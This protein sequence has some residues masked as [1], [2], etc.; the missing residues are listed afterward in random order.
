MHRMEKLGSIASVWNE[1]ASG[2]QRESCTSSG[3]VR[4][5]DPFDRYNVID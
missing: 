4:L 3:I 5:I 1:R 2:N